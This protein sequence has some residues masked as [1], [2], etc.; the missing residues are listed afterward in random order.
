MTDKLTRWNHRWSQQWNSKDG[1]HRQC[2][3]CGVK[4]RKK[5][6][7]AK[8]YEYQAKGVATWTDER[9]QCKPNDYLKFT[10]PDTFHKKVEKLN[11]EKQR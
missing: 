11:E 2:E 6:G 3:D 9:P 10:D 8:R 5:T 4:Q 1:R 7:K